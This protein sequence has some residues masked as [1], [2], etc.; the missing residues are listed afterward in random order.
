MPESSN[1]TLPGDAVTASPVPPLPG[2]ISSDISFQTDLSTPRFQER[3]DLVHSTPTGALL[4]VAGGFLDAFTYTA[5]DHVFANAMTGNV[6]LLGISC[7]SRNWQD[8]LRHLPPIAAFL[9]GICTA[10]GIHLY[11]ERRN[12]RFPYLS[13]LLLEIVTLAIL[14]FLPQNTRDFWIT[15]S[16]AF[17]A[18]VQVATFRQVN[19]HGYS[20][21]FT[22]GNLRTLGEA[23]FDWIFAGRKPETLKRLE[24]FAMIC[25][26]FFLGALIGA[27]ATPRMGNRA[28]WID[29]V[30]LL[31]VAVRLLQQKRWDARDG[32]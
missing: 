12:L 18:S 22:T 21:T 29:L 27:L 1:P 17:A 16:I 11:A 4:A 20:S 23:I 19:G 9:C 26:A 30:L 25:G 31:A 3:A 28:L 8:G 6:I 13:V 24:D 2:T 15:T 32:V 5:H 10:R 14:S 7:V